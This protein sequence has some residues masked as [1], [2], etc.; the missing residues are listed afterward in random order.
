MKKVD[1]FALL[2]TTE[3]ESAG[4]QNVDCSRRVTAGKSREIEF[5]ANRVSYVIEGVMVWAQGVESEGKW[6]SKFARNEATLRLQSV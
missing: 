3:G 6:D 2:A 1:R 4:A 5:V